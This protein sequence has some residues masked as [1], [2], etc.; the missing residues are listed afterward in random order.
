VAKETTSVS[1]TIVWT[2]HGSAATFRVWLDGKDFNVQSGEPTYTFTGLKPGSC[3]LV[4]VETVGSDN[5]GP[6]TPATELCVRPAGDVLAPRGVHT[7]AVRPTSVDLQWT[8]STSPGVT[9]YQVVRD[10]VTVASDLPPTATRYTDIGLVAAHHY[11]YTVRALAGGEAS[12]ESGELTVTTQPEPTVAPPPPPRPQPPGPPT[13][14][15]MSDRTATSI[16]LTWQPPTSNGTGGTP[17]YVVRVD[18]TDRPAVSQPP[19]TIKGLQPGHTYTFRVYATS[20]GLRSNSSNPY[21]ATTLTQ[22]TTNLSGTVDACERNVAVT[23]NVGIIPDGRAMRIVLQMG[24]S[25]GAYL[26][27]PGDRTAPNAW[28]FYK[29]DFGDVHDRNQIFKVYAVLL[30][31]QESS[32]LGT[33]AVPI[34]DDWPSVLRDQHGATISLAATV[35]RTSDIC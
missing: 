26:M 2:P 15:A 19:T 12:P 30:S 17:T 21:T 4:S 16:T 33:D 27:Q 20:G 29:L 25:D 32:D 10:G 9:G 7:T 14:L 1:L 28:I 13:G 5:T 6:R 35:K 24:G 3:H 18:N 8:L 11:V 31:E 34:G 22:Y 23:D